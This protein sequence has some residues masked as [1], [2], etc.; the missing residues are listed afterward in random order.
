[1]CWNIELLF[2]FPYFCRAKPKPKQPH[3]PTQ[4]TSSNQPIEPV[5]PKAF[6]LEFGG[7]ETESDWRV[8]VVFWKGL[9]VVYLNNEKGPLVVYGLQKGD[10]ILPISIGIIIHSGNLT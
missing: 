9:E 5:L 1:M 3:N 10:E 2:E 6:S 8:M 7:P 4:P